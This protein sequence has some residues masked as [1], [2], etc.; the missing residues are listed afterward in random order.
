MVTTISSW[1][2]LVAKT[3]QGY[4]LDAPTVFREA[5]LDDAKLADPD[6]RFSYEKMTRLWNLAIEKTGDPCFGLSCARHWHPTTFHA[7]GFAWLASAT[8]KDALERFVRYGRIMHDALSPR[9]VEEGAGYRLVLA[10]A[11]LGPRPSVA[12]IDSSAAVIVQLCRVSCGEEF[13]PLRVQLPHPRSAC[14]EKFVAFFRCPIDYE[15]AELA[16]VFERQS[17]ERVL[18]TGNK[19]LAYSNEKVIEEY[20]AKLDRS[21][22]ETQVRAAIIDRLP[23]GYVNEDVVADMLHMSRRTLQRKLAE[24]DATFQRLLDDTRRHLATDY[25]QRSQKSINE[26]T[27]LLGFSEPSNF[28]RAF[29]RWHGVSPSAYREGPCEQ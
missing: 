4:G 21:T 19:F 13:A 16:V 8:V 7:L 28:T 3:L 14:H 5:G 10:R 25:I 6:A 2:L 24:G 20:L 22:I 23:S 26:V 18:P 29:R 15:A 9:L 1:G 17:L 27:Y 11:P 12:S